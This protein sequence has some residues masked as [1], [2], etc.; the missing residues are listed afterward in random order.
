LALACVHHVGELLVRAVD[1]AQADQGA[2][3][4]ALRTLSAIFGVL[5]DCRYAWS[6]LYDPTMPATGE[7]HAA[8]TRYRGALSSIGAVGTAA[9][10]R[11]AGDHDQLDHALFNTVWQYTVTTVVRWRLDHPEQ[12]VADMTGRC[13][14]SLGVIG[15]LAEA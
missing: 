4:R 11:G 1:D 13:T 14:R 7:V 6:V 9:V 2:G 12:S 15:G 5:V 8:V 10:L 3:E